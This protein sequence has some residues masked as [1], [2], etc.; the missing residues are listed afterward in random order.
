ME[1]NRFVDDG[2]GIVWL[3]KKE[4]K[5]KLVVR[6][7]LVPFKFFDRV[8]KRFAGLIA[9][10][11][12]LLG[13]AGVYLGVGPYF[14]Y[15]NTDPAHN[16]LVEP[17]NL[18]DMVGVVLESTVTIYCDVKKGKSWQG[19]G[20]AI[21]LP[22]TN[23]KKYS[24]AI[25]T[26]HHV[27]ADCLNGKGIV[28]VKTYFGKEFAAKVARWD[29][30]NDLAL[31]M[32]KAK[33]DPLPLSQAIPYP[34]YWVMAA[35]TAD[36]YEG[37][38]SFGNVMNG[39]DTEVLITVPVSHGNSGGPLIDNEGKVIGTNAWHEIGEQYNG[40]VSLDAMCKKIMKCKSK[41]YWSRD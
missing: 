9:V 3:E 36:G 27:I 20:W 2:E 5:F 13:G 1:E 23:K 29:S 33:V 4:S 37:S 22:L 26:N 11:A 39:T 41:F 21:D 32:T 25:I 18:E 19:S 16:G 7:F 15:V 35:G 34:G 10:A 8:A 30:K 38:I 14:H 12:L 28:K 6:K 40:A 31:I 24:S 17:R